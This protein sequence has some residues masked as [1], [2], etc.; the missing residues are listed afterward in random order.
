[1]PLLLG[2]PVSV[3]DQIPITLGGG[4]ETEIYLVDIADV[5]LGES[6]GITIAV[7]DVVSYRDENA[8]FQS[9]FSMDQS[10]LRAIECVDLVVKYDTSVQVLTGTNV[11]W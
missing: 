7:S 10:V 1:M 8:T 6:L 5:M 4:A 11:T 9:A 3:T 2:Y